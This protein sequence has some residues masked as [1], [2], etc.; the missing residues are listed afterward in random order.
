MNRSR[1]SRGVAILAVVA[2]GVAVVSPAF[3]AAPLT[4]A[5]VKK[6]AR[7]QVKRVGDPRFINES[8]LIDYGPIT[9]PVGGTAPVQTIGPFSFTATCALE[10]TGV[11]P[12]PLNGEVLIDTSEDNSSFDADDDSEDDFDAADPAEEWAQDVGNDPDDFV[13]DF[14]PRDV[15]SED[16]GEGKAVSPSGT[17]IFGQ[18]TILTD[19]AAQSC[20]FWGWWIRQGSAIHI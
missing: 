1:L 12:D 5:K 16:D 13:A 15:N 14:P 7:K 20:T 2:L 6:I 18:T 9:V 19:F 4:K 17:S 10:D 8:E 3:S 11:D